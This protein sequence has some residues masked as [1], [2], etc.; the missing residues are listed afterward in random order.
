MG[1]FDK[2][3]KGGDDFDSPVENI[4]L[5]APPAVQPAASAPAPLAASTPTR[6]APEP[7]PDAAAESEMDDDYDA[8]AYGIDDAIELMRSL[9]TDNVE[10]VVQ[11]VKKTLESTKVKVRSIIDDASRKQKDIEGRIDV[12]KKEIAEYEQEIA[13]RREEIAKLEADHAE[14]TTVKE[15]LELAEKLTTGA[16]GSAKPAPAS[17]SGPA[18]HPK[19]PAVGGSGGR[20]GASGSG[21]GS[22]PSTGT[23][24]KGTTIIAKK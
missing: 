2:R 8:P 9:P 7:D 13:T 10:L 6:P 23:S 24:P 19:T 1:L 22:T 16:R 17:A 20:P 21:T 18:S 11:V 5:N 15:R 14:T 3:K 12:L 4:D